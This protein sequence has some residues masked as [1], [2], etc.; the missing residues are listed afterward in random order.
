MAAGPWYVHTGIPKGPPR[1]NRQTYWMD[2][3]LFYAL[4]VTRRGAPTPYAMAYVTLDMMKKSADA[5]GD[6]LDRALA[7]LRAITK[8][9]WLKPMT[10]DHGLMACHTGDSYDAA[11]ALLICELTDGDPA[12]WLVAVPS[13]DWL[14]ARKVELAGVKHFHEVQILAARANGEQPYPI[15]DRVYWVRPGKR[16]VEFKVKIDDQNVNV[17]PPKGFME[18]LDGPAGDPAAD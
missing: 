16:W 14:F 2:V 12:G 3:R 11:R 17:Y 1:T 8:P 4:S 15:S 7:N 13:R 6:W 9:D 5:P 18:A 10:G